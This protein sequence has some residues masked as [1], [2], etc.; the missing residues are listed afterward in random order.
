VSQVNRHG[1]WIP[2]VAL[3]GAALHLAGLANRLHELWTP[4]WLTG[5]TATQ[6]VKRCCGSGPR[7]AF[8]ASGGWR[9]LGSENG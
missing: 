1:R 7:L 3:A 5:W 2:R 8:A 6:D 4:A 9:L